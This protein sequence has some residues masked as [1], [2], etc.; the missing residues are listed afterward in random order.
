[1]PPGPPGHHATDASDV[2]TKAIYKSFQQQGLC[3]VD[4]VFDAYL[5][6]SLKSETR[7]RRGSG[8]RISVRETTPIWR[9]LQQFLRDDDSKTELFRLLADKLVSHCPPNGMILATKIFHVVKVGIGQPSWI[10]I[11]EA[12]KACY[13][14][15]K[16]SCKKS[17][18]GR[19]K[20]RHRA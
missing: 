2:F 10:T 17:C 7:E 12:S 19:C 5:K 1:M 11:P 20:C 8:T 15:I 6:D 9:K 3:R 13:E 14:L 4:V 16:F 18:R